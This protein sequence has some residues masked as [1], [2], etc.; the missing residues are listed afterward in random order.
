MKNQL[1]ETERELQD[2]QSTYDRDKAL[3][4]GKVQFLE[5]Q[6]DNYKKDLLESQRKFEITLDQ[7]QKRGTATKERQES[8]QQAILKVLESKY[9]A[10]IKELIENQQAATNEQKER[11][12][13]LEAE[14]SNANDKINAQGK[15]K[16]DEVGQLE[17]KLQETK[18]NESRLTSALN[19]LQTDSQRKVEELQTQLQR[20]KDQFKAKLADAEKKAKDAEAKRAQMLF[21]IEKER[22]NWQLEED[23]LRRKQAELEEFIQN[24]EKSKE[25]LKKE[26][27]KLRSDIRGSSATGSKKQFIFN[28]GATHLLNQTAASISSQLPIKSVN[29][30]GS[31]TQQD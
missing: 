14:L 26:N 29:R 20:D 12:K 24:L 11:C 30:S 31:F 21:G 13:K 23:H 16:G 1:S 6:K 3:W 4:E 9:K 2:L 22:A 15:S 18:A 19:E 7:L 25:V 5:Q 17:K 10:Q 28:K 27:S 8:S